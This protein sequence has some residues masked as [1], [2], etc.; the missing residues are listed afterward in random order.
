[1]QEITYVSIICRI[2][3]WRYYEQVIKTRG[4]G[5]LTANDL[6]ITLD[7]GMELY[8]LSRTHMVHRNI[9]WTG[10]LGQVSWIITVQHAPIGDSTGHGAMMQI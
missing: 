9:F 4:V 6:R 7:M 10:S 8:L 2:R 5:A 1:M 3:N